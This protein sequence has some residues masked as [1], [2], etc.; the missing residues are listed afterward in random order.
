MIISAEDAYIDSLKTK[1]I[2]IALAVVLIA[3]LTT[4]SMLLSWTPE[5]SDVILGIQGHYFLP[6]LP[7]FA[8][9]AGKGLRVLARKIT[10][11][12]TGTVKAVASAAYP[13]TAF[14]LVLAFYFIMRLYLSR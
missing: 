4:P 5:G 2:L 3:L 12:N 11:G 14:M 10:K 8:M 13:C 1:D 6:V 9:S 7:L